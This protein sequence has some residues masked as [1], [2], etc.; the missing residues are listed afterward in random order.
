MICAAANAAIMGQTQFGR[1]SVQ[2]WELTT[3][4]PER[5]SRNRRRS[6][7]LPTPSINAYAQTG[8]GCGSAALG[9]PWLKRICMDRWVSVCMSTPKAEPRMHRTRRGRLG[10]ILD[11]M[12]AGSVILVVRGKW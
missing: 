7:S 11:I 8:F 3:E 2:P 5:Q 12:G 10:F 6:P 1:I 4:S 9:P